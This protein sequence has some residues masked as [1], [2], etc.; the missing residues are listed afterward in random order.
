MNNKIAKT[1]YY[2][3][4]IWI[5]IIISPIILVSAFYVT[6]KMCYEY[7]INYLNEIKNK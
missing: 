2:I 6:F 4:A 7:I 5:T 1:I 3:L